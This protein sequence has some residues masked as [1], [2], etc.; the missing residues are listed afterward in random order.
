MADEIP[1][2]WI[3]VL[4]KAASLIALKGAD[5][6][7]EPIPRAEF[8]MGLGFS[9]PEAGKLLGYSDAT[10]RMARSRAKAKK[11]GRNGKVKSGR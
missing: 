4:A 9:Q 8:L 7:D 3:E 1:I 6:E 2:R 5:I 11:G 10:L